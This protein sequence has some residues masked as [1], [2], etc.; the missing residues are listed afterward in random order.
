[1]TALVALQGSDGCVASK[2][3]VPAWVGHDAEAFPIDGG[4]VWMNV[5]ACDAALT[6]KM[7]EFSSG[8]LKDDGNG[9]P[10]LAVDHE[11]AAKADSEFIACEIECLRAGSP[12][13]FVD[14]PVPGLDEPSF[15][16]PVTQGLGA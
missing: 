5:E 4:H 7:I 10:T 8:L 9:Q 12:V 2:R 3:Q 13:L 6:A 11:A 15:N 14:L 16:S 1:M